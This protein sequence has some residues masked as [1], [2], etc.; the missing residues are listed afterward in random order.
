MRRFSTSLF[1][2]LLIFVSVISLSAVAQSTGGVTG[3]VLDETGA[4]VAGV[5]ITV[6][7]DK[8]LA[9]ATSFTKM[10]GSFAV[11]G[12]P[13]GRYSLVVQ[14]KHFD[15]GHVVIEINENSVKV[16]ITV[17]LHIKTVTQEV[18]VT[19]ATRFD[20]KVEDLPISATVV[21]NDS[22][23]DSA[24]QSLDQLL[25]TVPGVNLQEP[26]S[27]AQHPTSNAENAR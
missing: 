14:A 7:D 12:I 13:F 21:T 26:P 27:F 15:D 10:D 25:L 8:G 18:T 11:D 5:R 23:Q 19:A 1:F 22:I 6:A 9:H 3:T 20:S 17:K 4:A 2:S 16:P 24:A